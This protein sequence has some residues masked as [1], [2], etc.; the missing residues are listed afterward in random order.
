MPAISPGVAVRRG[1]PGRRRAPRPARRDARGRRR[2]A[3]ARRPDPD[4]HAG[5]RV[6]ADAPSRGQRVSSTDERD[7][8]T[9][10]L[11]VERRRDVGAAGRG[12]GRR[13]H[14]VDAGRPPARRASRPCPATSC[15]ATC[16]ASATRTTSSTARAEHGGMLFGG[17]EAD[18][19]ARAGRTACPWDH[20]ATLAAARLGA[21][22][23]A[24]GGR[25]PALPVPRRRGGGPARLPSRRDDARREPAHRA[26]ARACAGSG[27]PL[28]C[29]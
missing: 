12:D 9:T 28:G 20:A 23:A 3:R 18:P 22:R 19:R 21:L 24:D 11:V 13:V 4:R 29:R 16:P 5:D 10:E 1:P 2:G 8:S 27:S 7:R 14:P 6:R 15:R 17:Y 25:D 26:A